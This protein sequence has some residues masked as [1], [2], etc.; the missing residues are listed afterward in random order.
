MT[1]PIVFMAND[2]YAHWARPFLRSLRDQAPEA[3]VFCIPYA[4]DL[5]LIRALQ[6]EF[7]FTLLAPDFTAIDAFADDCFP[8]AP[9]RRR[10]LR[11]LAALD[12][13]GG[14]FLYLDCDML[15]TAP[16]EEVLAGLAAA[17]ADLVYFAVSDQYVYA[18]AALPEM[19]ARF[20]AAPLMSAGSYA[21]L[22]PGFGSARAMALIRAEWDLY[23]RVR[24][25]FVFD[26]PVLNLVSQLAGFRIL[27]LEDALPGHTGD[28]FFRDPEIRPDDAGLL[29]RHGRR[30]VALHWAGLDKSTEAPHLA[31]LA[32][33]YG[34]P[35]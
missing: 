9:P 19:R 34:L 6:D 31:A 29:R 32:A 1:L 4:E 13:P 3:R 15:V 18:E 30:V 23:R 33:R 7:G 10:N 20:P 11:K 24:S 21:L 8:G 28:G 26:Q 2:A 25:P 27:S 17:P 5:V 12:L 16:L 14:P 22:R 35:G